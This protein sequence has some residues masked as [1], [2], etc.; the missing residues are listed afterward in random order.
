MSDG[1]RHTIVFREPILVPGL[2]I[3][4]GPVPTDQIEQTIGSVLEQVLEPEDEDG[5]PEGGDELTEPAGRQTY[6]F[7]YSSDDEDIDEATG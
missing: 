6:G 7:A 2:T 4:S 3:I 5:D 1:I